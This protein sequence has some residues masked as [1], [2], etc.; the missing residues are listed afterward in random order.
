MPT[1][2]VGPQKIALDDAG[3]LV[4]SKRYMER[5]DAAVARVERY[6]RFPAQDT[7]P[8]RRREASVLKIQAPSGGI[9]AGGSAT[10][11]SV[12]E[13]SGSAWVTTGQTLAT[14]YNGCGSTAVGSLAYASVAW[15][16]GRWETLPAC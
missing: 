9:A 5:V 12:V 10:N 8:A 11:V 3:V 15:V 6:Y 14:V 4:T 7:K 13:W 2:P 1:P 16:S